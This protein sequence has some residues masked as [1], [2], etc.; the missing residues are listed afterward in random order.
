MKYKA[1]II[2][3]FFL[4]ALY[5]GQAQ[6]INVEKPAVIHSN[7]ET[8][9]LYVDGAKEDWTISPHLKPD[10]LRIYSATENVK[11]IKFITD[12][13]SIEFNVNVNHPV[14]F[15]IVLKNKD[16]AY[17]TIDFNN[18]Y[19]KIL[20]PS[21]KI[22]ALSLFWSEVK[23][24]FAFIDKLKFNLDSLYKTYVDKIENTKNDFEFYDQM[25]RFAASFKDAH[26]TID[27]NNGS[28]YTDYIP[29][30]CKYFKDDLLIIVTRKD[31]ADLYPVGSKILK[32]NGLSVGDYM[33]EYVDPYIYSDFQP[34]VKLLEAYNI[35][36]AKPLTDTISITYQTPNGEIRSGTLP[37]DG[38]QKE[39][40]EEN[41]GYHPQRKNPFE[42]NWE[43]GKIAVV[44]I[45]TFADS[46][47]IKE[48]EK[49]KDTLY[50]AKGII[51]DLRKNNGGS[52]N[53]AWHFLKYIIQDTF[54]LN[55]AWQTRVN[56]GVKKA[57]GNYIKANA[58]YLNNKAFETHVPDTIFI[59]ANIKKFKVPV[60]VLISSQTVSAAEDFL[61][62]L[63][64]RTDRPLFIGQPSF[65]ST[66]SPL[67]LW[68]FPKNG[69]AR[70][71]TRRVLFPYSL[72]P[73]TEGITPDIQ[74]DYTFEEFM[75]P[76]LDKEIDAAIKEIDKSYKQ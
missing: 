64:E 31:I 75:N 69:R 59:P 21:D 23:Y 55:F 68:N 25:Q 8:I 53:V 12:V 40:T 34:T 43:A 10:Y 20:S 30:L 14:N 15:S 16:T 37:R 42:I 73:F 22:Y 33:K 48:F 27:Y 5:S 11:K 41:I 54:F 1:V 19:E 26:T 28:P 3:L 65:G 76:Q 57:N 47:V 56:D 2:F 29:L 46:N 13:D 67:V 44:S 60:V 7:K 45:N 17:T 39:N 61:I 38:R 63:K 71:C 18:Q 24:N 66:G 6:L 72:K 70:I 51:I 49:A 36:S 35:F 32:I 4:L 9:K 50:T 74:I 62:I 52:T 58:D